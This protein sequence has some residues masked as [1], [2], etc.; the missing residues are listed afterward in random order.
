[1]V[2]FKRQF[3]FL[4][5][6]ERWP[7]A[8]WCHHLGGVYNWW[9]IRVALIYPRH[10][11]SLALILTHMYWFIRF[12]QL[13]SFHSHWTGGLLIVML[14][15][16]CEDKALIHVFILE[17]NNHNHS[18]GSTVQISS[19]SW[20][21]IYSIQQFLWYIRAGR[22]RGPVHLQAGVPWWWWADI[23]AGSRL[24]GSTGGVDEGAGP[25][26][27]RLPQTHG[28]RT[29]KTTGWAQW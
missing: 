29:T 17:Y 25:S 2:C 13:T 22:M 21:K 1:M 12:T 8:N 19:S 24:P 6:E 11:A 5:W 3:A 23:C 9:V 16:V 26:F 15:D 18:F 7:W 4:L 20:L 10:S 27:L 14:H 28:G